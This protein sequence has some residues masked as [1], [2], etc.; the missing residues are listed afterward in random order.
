MIV[1]ID[2]GKKGAAVFMTE[3]GEIIDI[4]EYSKNTEW[5]IADAFLEYL[6]LIKI[7]FIEN[8]TFR[9]GFKGRS[10]FSE[11]FGVWKGILIA[12]KIPYELVSPAKWQRDMKCLT[13]GDKKVTKAKAQQLF[14]KTKVTLANADAIL[15]AEYCR[16]CTHG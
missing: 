12:L 7:V 14:P 15:I 10:V 1:G 4:L 8:V 3:E 6:S 16:R 5:D 13:K 9:P 11:N 2:P